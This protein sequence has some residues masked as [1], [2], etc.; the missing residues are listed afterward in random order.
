ME[1]T[2]SKIEAVSCVAQYEAGWRALI[3]K[4]EGIEL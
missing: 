2:E 1:I 4:Y 3:K